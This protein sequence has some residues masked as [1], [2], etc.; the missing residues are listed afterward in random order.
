MATP[1][2]AALRQERHR[3][4]VSLANR[5]RVRRVD[6]GVRSATFLATAIGAAVA[7]NVAVGVATAAPSAQRCPH[8]SGVVVQARTPEVVIFRRGDD[9]DRNAR[10]CFRS[11]GL[12]RTLGPQPQT[13]P[14]GPSVTSIH[15]AGHFVAYMRYTA[16]DAYTGAGFSA[17]FRR[18][19]LR[20]NRTTSYTGRQGCG[21]ASVGQI[22]VDRH[23]SVAW[24]CQLDAAGRFFHLNKLDAK[25]PRTLFVGPHV[26]GPTADFDVAYTGSRITWYYGDTHGGYTLKPPSR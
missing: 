24:W 11:T 14:T 7:G 1:I 17:D 25:G 19:N 13:L 23:G 9:P 18:L 20:T 21:T 16:G 12:T 26:P 2:A 5:R 15:A 4:R 8:G 22:Y 10:A 6:G 3:L